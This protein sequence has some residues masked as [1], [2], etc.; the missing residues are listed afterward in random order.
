MSLTVKIGEAKTR[1][2]E[3]LAKVEA[4][5]EIVIARGNEPVA[6]LD[7]AFRRRGGVAAPIAE[8]KASARRRDAPRRTPEEIL[9]WRRRRTSLLMAFVV[10]ASV[11]AGWFLPDEQNRRADAPDRRLKAE[12]GDR[13]RAVLVRD[14]QPVSS[15]RGG[16]TG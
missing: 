12:A 4:G 6:R 5:E 11:A 13:A 2:S 3:L 10:D 16:E 15:P 7:R 14:A 8:V 9:A 1:L